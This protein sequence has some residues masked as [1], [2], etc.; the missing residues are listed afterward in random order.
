[1]DQYKNHEINQHF[2][3]FLS[4]NPH[5]KFPI[6]LLQRSVLV[7][8]EPPKGIKESM[9]RL[10]TTNVDFERYNPDK[11][12]LEAPA[13]LE[14]DEMLKFK[15][16]VWCLA[17]LHTIIT[18]RR[19][20]KSLGWDVPYDFNDSDFNICKDILATYIKIASK[21]GHEDKKDKNQEGKSKKKNDIQWEAIQFLIGE[22]NYGGR[23]TA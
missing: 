6:T 4:S 2:R 13:K 3:L 18:E 7:T 9:K 23:V 10:Y 11:P 14:R 20:F 12:E 17:W 21:G 15:K 8:T 19:K 16:L 1:M 22:A 5:P